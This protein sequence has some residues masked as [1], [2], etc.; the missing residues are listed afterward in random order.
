M[1]NQIELSK[2]AGTIGNVI[3]QNKAQ[4]DS[5]TTIGELVT[6]C[7]ELLANSNNADKTNFLTTL[8]N[9]KTWMRGIEYVYNYMLKGDNLGVI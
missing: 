5:T 7:K 3:A 2:T 4:I 1:K 6:V 9:K 8:S